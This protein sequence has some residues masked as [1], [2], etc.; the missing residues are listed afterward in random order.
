ML[1]LWEE[2]REREGEKEMGK[3]TSS[4]QQVTLQATR[5]QNPGSLRPLLRERRGCW[6]W[7]MKCSP[8]DG[9][10]VCHSC[11]TPVLLVKPTDSKV[12]LYQHVSVPASNHHQRPLPSA[13]AMNKKKLPII[14]GSES[15]ETFE[16]KAEIQ[17]KL[18]NF[19]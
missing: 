2:N 1:G 9:N 19:I 18:S 7:H 13:K 10:A 3:T 17:A 15:R 16:M 14:P 12:A 8:S 6:H 4:L 5:V 11:S